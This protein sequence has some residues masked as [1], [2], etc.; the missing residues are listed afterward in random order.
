L[1][2]VPA[3]LLGI[4][5]SFDADVHSVATLG[6]VPPDSDRPVE[7]TVEFEW[8]GLR[9]PLE[10]GGP[11]TRGANVTSADALIVAETN[12]GRR[13]A[14]LCEWKYAEKYALDH[15]LGDGSSG[16]TR[17]QQCADRY[18]S[19]TS[20]FCGDVPLN[21]LLYDPVYQILR[22]GLLGSKMVSEGEFGI[23]EFRVVV[24]C[25]AGNLSYRSTITSKPLRNRFPKAKT[26]EQAVRPLWKDP[27]QFVMTSQEVC[28]DEVR[29]ADTHGQLDDW[30]LYQKMRYGW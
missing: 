11:Y 14:Y 18:A 23:T 8:I 25:P 17:R 3:T 20:P 28:I 30:A 2:T 27:R 16:Q 26:I 4:L 9:T 15:D 21:E 22:L 1:A 19:S 13:R 10:K 24:V 12:I 29:K 7:A 5:R 6:Y